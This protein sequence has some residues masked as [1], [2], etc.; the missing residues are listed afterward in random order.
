MRRR[1]LLAL[2]IATAMLLSSCNSLPSGSGGAAKLETDDSKAIYA[3]GLSLARNLDPLALTPAEL[4]IVKQALTDSANKKP[5]IDLEVYGPKIND[6]AKGRL[7]KQAEAEKGK[8]KAYEEKMAAVAGAQKTPS[9]LI[10]KEI[11]PGTG[12]SPK[13]TDTVKVNYKGTLL[14]GTE[15]DSSYKRNMPAEFPLGG[16]IPCWTEGVQK[17]K[18]G[19][20]AQLVCPAALAYGDAGSP[21][22]IPGGATLTF[23][24]ELLSIGASPAATP[25][26]GG[27][28]KK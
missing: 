24:V 17:M 15:F 28:D 27:G 2:P 5:A 8:A 14:D 10:Y 18:V 6:F 16:V 25:N 21:P 1:Y 26:A 20:K 19:G 11:T 12:A 4:D 7:G 23:E 13:D 3:I 22:V 9:G